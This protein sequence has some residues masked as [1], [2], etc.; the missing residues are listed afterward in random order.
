MQKKI[1]NN[2]FFIYTILVFLIS[3]IYLSSCDD[4]PADSSKDIVLPDSNLNYSDHIFPLFTVKCG[5]EN[6]C[7]SPNFGGLPAKGLDLTDYNSIRTH[8]IDGS[9]HL[10]IENQGELSFLYN[11]LLS[12]ISG[13]R[14]MPPDREPLS[15]NNI[16]GVKTWIDEGA[17]QFAQPD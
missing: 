13:R 11:I 16:V 8:M 10:V 1:A 7:H 2:P 3:V 14:Q 17:H 5:S 6:G 12:P 9:E 15:I 4:N